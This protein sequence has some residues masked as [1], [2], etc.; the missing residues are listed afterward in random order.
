MSGRVQSVSEKYSILRSI[1]GSETFSF[2]AS[3]TIP[4]T[5]NSLASRAVGNRSITKRDITLADA[6]TGNILSKAISTFGLVA[7]NDIVAFFA[8][9]AQRLRA[10]YPPGCG[11]FVGRA[12]SGFEATEFARRYCAYSLSSD[13]IEIRAEPGF[14]PERAHVFSQ[15]VSRIDALAAARDVESESAQC[16]PALL[17]D[18]EDSR[19]RRILFRA[20]RVAAIGRRFQRKFSGPLQDAPLPDQNPAGP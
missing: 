9:R 19:R 4:E 3:A 15:T 14:L 6:I 20:V 13:W 7:R 18:A 10:G 11:T 2:C 5:R 8:L 12:G 16:V 1:S 17:R